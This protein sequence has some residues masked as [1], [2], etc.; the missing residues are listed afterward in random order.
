[1]ADL[2]SEQSEQNQRSSQ[3][4]GSPE[5]GNTNMNHIYQL[6]KQE[7]KFSLSRL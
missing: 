5:N 2:G 6:S 7:I 1:M 3:S 4:P